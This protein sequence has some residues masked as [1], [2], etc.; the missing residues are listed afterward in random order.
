VGKIFSKPQKRHFKNFITSV[1]DLDGR[2]TITRITE[3]GDRQCDVSNVIKFIRDTSWKKEDLVKR[4][5]GYFKEVAKPSPV[6]FLLF[7]DSILEKRCK[8]KK[9]EGLGWHYSHTKGKTICGHC[10][11]SSHYRYGDI[12]FPY[13][14]EMYYSE[15][16]AKAL[17]EPFKTKID[18]VCDSI[19]QFHP[20]GNEKVYVVVDSWYS[21]SRVIGAAQSKGFEFIGGL[22]S[23]RTFKLRENG[24]KHKLWVYAKNV[25][26]TSLDE[27][28]VDG[29]AYLVRRVNCWVTGV[30]KEVVILISKRK[31]DG[32]RCFI[33]STDTSLS[34]EE[35]IRYYSYRWD[36]ETGYLYCKDRLGLG[37]YQMRSMKA[38]TK[39]CALI[40]SAFCYLEALRLHNNQ[41]SIGQSRKYFKVR[42]KKELVNKI[43]YL[44][45]KGVPLEKIYEE[46][47]I[48]A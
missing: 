47:K 25:R 41:S 36:I 24:P 34:N 23:N 44:V 48:V 15:K 8:P 14:F 39:Y 3:N 16:A 2:K 43:V 9:M 38:I 20:F 35:I 18:I 26:N 30:D 27:I 40:F 46:L 1:I 5:V 17:H 12:S 10:L 21:S 19:R 22:K 13:D 42:R 6:G 37:Q 31:K 29:V 33:L 45:K 28:I 11:V 32:S 7:D 4:N